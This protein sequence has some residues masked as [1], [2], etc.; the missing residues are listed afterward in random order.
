LNVV[1]LNLDSERSRSKVRS[2]I[3]TRRYRFHVALDPDQDIYRRLNGITLPYTL[4]IDTTG[5][6]VYRHTG[7]TPGDEQEL[8]QQ[9]ISLLNRSIPSASRADSSTS[10]QA[11]P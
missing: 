6:I 7:Y 11:N 4:L 8:E 9:I 1:A 5:E 10:G 2:Y 3:R